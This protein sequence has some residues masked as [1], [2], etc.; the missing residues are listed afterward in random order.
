LI[1]D[2]R[3]LANRDIWIVVASIVDRLS[4][5]DRTHH[6]RIVRPYRSAAARHVD[7]FAKGA[8]GSNAINFQRSRATPGR[9]EV[10]GVPV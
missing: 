1:V 9:L 5:R 4:A 7:C 3:F 8:R 6:L 2:T 10:A